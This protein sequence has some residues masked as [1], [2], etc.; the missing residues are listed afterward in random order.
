MKTYCVLKT[1][2]SSVSG[3]GRYLVNEARDYR[4][5]KSA[6]MVMAVDCYLGLDFGLTSPTEVLCEVNYLT[7]LFTGGY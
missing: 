6:A 3:I 5:R 1:T 2:A 7:R 4:K